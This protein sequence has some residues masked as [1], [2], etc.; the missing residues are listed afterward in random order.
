MTINPVNIV[1]FTAISRTDKVEAVNIQSPRADYTKI[2]E[3]TDLLNASRNTS[4]NNINPEYSGS[5]PVA[6]TKNTFKNL[7]ET[8]KKQA[9]ENRPAGK[10]DSENEDLIEDDKNSPEIKRKEL[11]KG[12]FITV[13][14]EKKPED[15][16]NLPR[17]SNI[18]EL[19]S[20]YY[21]NQK[22]D[23]GKLVDMFI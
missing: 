22:L 10:I 18:K 6:G 2:Q 15:N 5:A 1:Q 9:P 20:F 7:L 16:S 13:P 11:G 14:S 4:I 8:A 21:M 17:L 19:P 12:F 23:T 3:T